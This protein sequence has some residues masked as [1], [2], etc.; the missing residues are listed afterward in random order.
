MRQTLVLICFWTLCCTATANSLRFF[1]DIK[2]PENWVE[3][4]PGF[5]KTCIN[6]DKA[7][8]WVILRNKKVDVDITV[9][10]V[11]KKAEEA[12]KALYSNLKDLDNR[13]NLN[14]SIGEP[15]EQDGTW[16]VESI[17]GA[18]KDIWYFT[19]NNSRYSIISIS[20]SKNNSLDHG[21]ALLKK[22][23][24]IDPTLFPKNY[25]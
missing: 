4:D 3:I 24:P 6:G 10:A 20:T 5:K 2:L 14:A 11:P 25:N 16:I 15:V 13:Y 8:T 22:L 12:A 19:G 17:M 23:R 9:C 21:K 1:H 18:T 7:E